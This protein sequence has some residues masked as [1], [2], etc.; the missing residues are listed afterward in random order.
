MGVDGIRAGVGP[1]REGV[2]SSPVRGDTHNTF[3]SGPV[4]CAV[5]WLTQ[6]LRLIIFFNLDDKRQA[7][8]DLDEAH[9]AVTEAV[10]MLE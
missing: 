7:V 5:S 8:L 10:E 3:P 9:N 2:A 4:S 6:A 1:K